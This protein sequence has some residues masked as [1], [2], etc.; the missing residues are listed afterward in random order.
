[1]AGRNLESLQKQY[2]KA[3]VAGKG[4]MPGRGPGGPE[5][6]EGPEAWVANPR[7]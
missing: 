7:T 4:G 6:P 2:N 3:A 5:V 1:M